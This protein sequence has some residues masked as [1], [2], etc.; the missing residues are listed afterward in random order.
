MKTF[1]ITISFPWLGF[2]KYKIVQAFDSQDEQK[3]YIGQLKNH[4]YF[5]SLSLSTINYF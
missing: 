3:F 1:Q 2:I 4:P 5:G